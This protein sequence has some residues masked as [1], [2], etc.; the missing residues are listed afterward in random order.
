MSKKISVTISNLPFP[1]HKAPEVEKSSTE[2]G[3]KIGKAIEGEWFKRSGGGDMCR[4]YSQY[5]EFHRLRLYARGEQP[6]GMYQEQF[7]VNGDNSYT[8]L[9]WS[10]VKILPKFVDIVVN[11]MNDRHYAIKAESQDISTASERNLFQEMVEADMVSK[12]FLQLTKEQFGVDAFN[13]KEDDIPES[14]EELSLYMQLKFKPSI[15]I[16]EEV[17][18][19]TL[20]ELN[21]YS[22]NVKPIADYDLTV[23]GKGAVKHSFNPGTGVTIEPV[24][25]ATL[26]HSYTEKP[27]HSDCFYYGEVKTVHYTEVRKINP[28]IT[29]EELE[30]IKAAGSAWS[31]YYP[32]ANQYLDDAF[33]NE[34]VTLLYFNYNTEKRFVYKKKFLKTKGERVIRRDESFNPEPTEDDQFVRQDVVKDVWYDGVLVL[35][36]NHLIKWELLKNMVRPKSATQK[37]RPN[38][39]V[40]SPRPYKGRVESLVSRMIPFADQIQLTHL[41]IQQVMS[42]IVPDGVFI[43]VD[44]LSEV[45]LGNGNAY[46]PAEA[47]NLYFQTG[48]VV[49]RSTTSDGDFN[50]AR[51][52]IEQLTSSGGASKLSG[53]F[54]VYNYNLNMIRDTTGLNEARDGS[55][56]DPDAAVG[57]AKIAALN[58]NTATRHILRAGLAI[59][60]RMAECLSLRVADI[61]EYSDFKE[62]FAMQIGKYNMAILEDIKD[63][64]LHSFGIFIELEPDEEEKAM[65]EA[66]IQIALAQQTIELEDAIDIR[67]IKNLKLANE[68]LKI[69]K[70]ARLKKMEER[71][72]QKMQMQAQ[73]NM[74]SQQ[75]AAE[76]AALKTQSDA[77]IKTAVKQAEAEGEIR[78]LQV[79]AE[80][81]ERLMGIEFSYQMQ[82][83]GISEEQLKER[84]KIKEDRKDERVDL[85]A[86]KQSKLID[87]RLNNLPAQN[88]ESEE[89]SVDGFSL[90]GFI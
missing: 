28:D 11:G 63:L 59:T 83:K 86:T 75:A 60:R 16:A 21:D 54:E 35:G 4:Y 14:T 48:S 46:S 33:N 22:E 23:C 56:P 47:L 29:D 82:L 12:Q 74:Q 61:L 5:A 87:Q 27:D 57:L 42:R 26:V 30:A 17:A 39:V 88:F 41:K 62:E 36:S 7:K 64:Y 58:S 73:I 31:Q 18:I 44:G 85:Q 2:Y 90:D 6:V 37:S 81:K 79:E 78:K 38:Y 51:I 53:L 77:Q 40:Y 65:I 8:N 49:G 70:K 76:A 84:E 13:I 10:I 43:D 20:L 68:L 89:D 52:P 67:N 32:I 69:K 50:R 66:N 24:D 72:D 25:V 34:N 55:N 9:D 45:D 1:S 3:L 80:L 15:E 71:E 19:N